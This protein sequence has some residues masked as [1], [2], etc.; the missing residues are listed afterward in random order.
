MP[1]RHHKPKRKKAKLRRGKS[2]GR[3][4]VLA[5][6]PNR[7]PGAK[8]Y[9][10]R[11]ISRRRPAPV[12]TV[13]PPS[14]SREPRPAPVR[15]VAP[16]SKSREP[17]PAPVTSSL[18]PAPEQQPLRAVVK[19]ARVFRFNCPNCDGLIEVE[20]IN[21]GIFRHGIRQVTGQQLNPHASKKEC[22]AEPIF[23]CGKPFRFDP[24]RGAEKC[25][26]I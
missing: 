17:R 20:H 26:Y 16:P 4:R 18:R 25:D 1:C 19:G 14:N 5:H 21:C 13:A 24:M 23:G 12:R 3:P 7:S 22:E 6:V 11:K 15:T 9:I 10:K 2:L 8:G